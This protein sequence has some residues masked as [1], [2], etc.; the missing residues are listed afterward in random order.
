MTVL[1]GIEVTHDLGLTRSVS[2]EDFVDA[3]FLRTALG[4]GLTA[5]RGDG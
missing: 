1:P 4:E 2:Y 3:V 5:M